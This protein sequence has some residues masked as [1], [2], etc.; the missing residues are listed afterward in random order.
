MKK[1]VILVYLFLVIFPKIIA[2]ENSSELENVTYFNLN[3]TIFIRAERFNTPSFMAGLLIDNNDFL[4]YP[5]AGLNQIFIPQI[6]PLLNFNPQP[7]YTI[8]Q[9]LFF[10]RDP[11]T[12]SIWLFLSPVILTTFIEDWQEYLINTQFQRNNN[13][14]RINNSGFLRFEWEQQWRREREMERERLQQRFPSGN[15]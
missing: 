15:N 14:S 3:S 2:D 1:I 12:F 11:V 8:P 10:P 5:L 7:E 9:L 6:N 13:E 4:L